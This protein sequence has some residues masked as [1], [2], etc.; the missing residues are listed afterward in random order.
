MKSLI[1]LTA[2]AAFTVATAVAGKP[3]YFATDKAIAAV[4]SKPVLMAE[5]RL[6]FDRD[7]SKN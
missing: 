7:R 5:Q 3:A 4:K 1:A 2:V 6:P